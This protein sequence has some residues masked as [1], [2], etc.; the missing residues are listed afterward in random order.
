MDKIDNMSRGTIITEEKLPAIRKIA[1]GVAY[2]G[3]LSLSQIALGGAVTFFYNIKMGL[4]PYWTGLAWI[5]FAI[6]NA[7][8]DPILGILEDRTKSRWGRRVPYLRFGAPFYAISFVLMWFP[9]FTASQTGLFFSFLLNLFVFDTLYSMIGLITYGLP[10]EMAVTAKARSNLIM[11]GAFISA[12]GS[13]IALVLPMVLLTGDES[14]T[15]NPV[16]RPTMIGLAIF[17]MS[18]LIWA[19]FHIKENKYTQNEN[20]LPLFKSVTETFKN[21]PFLIFEGANFFY[22]IAQTI[23][24]TGLFYFNEYVLNI[25]GIQSSLPLLLIYA[26]SLVFTL[27]WNKLNQRFGLKK[28]FIIALILCIL[29]GTVAFFVGQSYYPAMIVLIIFGIG[30][31]GISLN[32]GS[33]NADVIDFDELKTGKRRETTYSGINALITKPGISIANALFLFIIQS[34]G[35]PPNIDELA[36]Y[37]ATESVKLGIM[38]GFT[39]IPAIVFAVALIFMLFYPLDGPDWEKEKKK[40]LDIHL[41]KEQDYLKTLQEEH[42]DR[43]KS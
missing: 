40:I 9:F 42:G 27:M 24:F 6:W 34:F 18:C 4:E 8:N 19:S 33:I 43:L 15:L 17:S 20:A 30:Y 2:I 38:I 28:V 12:I 35:F 26:F 31:G 25:G 37:V 10:A 16:F 7:L 21:I 23:I 36:V 32:Q 41:K 13:V 3:N 11:V 39:I 22:T 14:S 29:S 1:Y 5:I